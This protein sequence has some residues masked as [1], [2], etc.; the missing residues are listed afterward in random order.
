LTSLPKENGEKI[1][2]NNKKWSQKGKVDYKDTSSLQNKNTEEKKDIKGTCSFKSAMILKI[3]HLI[4]KALR[5]IQD[6][7]P[8]CLQWN[9]SGGTFGYRSTSKLDREEM[10]GAARMCSETLHGENLRSW[11]TRHHNRAYSCLH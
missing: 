4:L 9:F 8:S 7:R 11:W 6:L 10:C 1:Q 5:W 2:S 3:P